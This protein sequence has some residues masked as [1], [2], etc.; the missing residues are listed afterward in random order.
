MKA[1]SMLCKAVKLTSL[2]QDSFFHSVLLALIYIMIG[3]LF[4][5]FSEAL[6]LS[7]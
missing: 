4:V 7:S 2:R 5:C 3:G 6:Q 1:H